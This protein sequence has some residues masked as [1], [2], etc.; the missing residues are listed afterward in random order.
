MAFVTDG[1]IPSSIAV[2][3]TI[4]TGLFP[5]QPGTLPDAARRTLEQYTR[6]GEDAT[7]RRIVREGLADSA[8]A[9]AVVRKLHGD[10]NGR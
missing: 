10:C 5:V 8:R 2:T 7:L 9:A 1:G 6:T 3:R 4:A